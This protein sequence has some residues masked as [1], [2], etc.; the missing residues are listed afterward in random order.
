[1]SSALKK[2]SA[3]PTAAE[4]FAGMKA[5]LAMFTSPLTP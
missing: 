3:L 2:V 5:K 1:V 4:I